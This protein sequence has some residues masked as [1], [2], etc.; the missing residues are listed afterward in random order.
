MGVKRSAGNSLYDRT[1]AAAAATPRSY[2]SFRGSA[3]RDKYNRP[4]GPLILQR[5]ALNHAVF[6]FAR[7][8]DSHMA[9]V[10]IDHYGVGGVYV[11]G[12]RLIR[13]WCIREKKIKLPKKRRNLSRKEE[14]L[15]R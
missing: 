12:M 7:P 2:T 15:V 4:P 1:T 9:F 13:L 5:K 10:F 11:T 14:I 3:A 8:F 6:V